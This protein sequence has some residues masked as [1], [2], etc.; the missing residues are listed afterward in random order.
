VLVVCERI[1][2]LRSLPLDWKFLCI[3]KGEVDQGDS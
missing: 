1:P 2:I 3:L